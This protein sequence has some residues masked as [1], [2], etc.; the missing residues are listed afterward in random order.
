VNK[1]FVLGGDNL[2]NFF[3]LRDEDFGTATKEILFVKLLFAIN[4]H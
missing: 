2:D 4:G 1:Y 3:D